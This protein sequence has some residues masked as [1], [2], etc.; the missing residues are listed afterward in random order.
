M[1]R[2]SHIKAVVIMAML[3][4]SVAATFSQSPAI[5]GLALTNGVLSV[6]FTGGELQTSPTVS[7]LW[8]GTGNTSG[9]YSESVVGGTNKFYRVRGQS[10]V[11]ISNVSLTN[12]TVQYNALAVG[13][14]VYVDRTNITFTGVASLGGS[15]YIQTANDDKAASTNPFLT[16]DVSTNVVI[17][18]AHDDMITPKPSWLSAFSDTGENLVGSNPATYSLYAAEFAAG[19][20]TLGGNEG[21][22]AS[23][24]YSV[25]ITPAPTAPPG[26]ATNPNPTNSATS[27][28]VNAVLS[29]TPGSKAF[30]HDV[31]FGTAN[32]PPFKGNQTATTYNPG[33][34]SPFTTYYWRINEKNSKGT[35][36]GTVWSFT[37]GAAAALTISNVS[38]VNYT[39]QYDALAVGQLIYVDRTYTFTN[40]ASLG[41]S[42]Y[43]K[44]ANGDKPSTAN[45]FLTFDVSANVVVYVAHDDKMTNK[46]SWLTSFS[47]TGEN[48]GMNTAT[49]S[50]YAAEFAA[51]TVTLG[52]NE[53][54]VS[55][56][57]YS[58]V[59]TPA[60]TGPPGTASNPNPTNSATSVSVNA[61]LSWTPGSKAFSHDVYFGTA[62]PPA[63]QG[64]QTG[65]TYNPGALSASTTYYWRINEKNSVG[66]TTGTVWSFTTGTSP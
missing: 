48:I 30:S 43:I 4:G 65:P 44:T 46:P 11:T 5:T 9:Q 50:L 56:S 37:T 25:V 61:I 24:M 41:G 1:K 16:F 22:G 63:F 12:Y 51:G 2:I 40:V 14:L 6:T 23:S 53:G 8:T 57:M 59:I 35:T 60:P 52:G 7:G 45:P 66:T 62:N 20:V 27:F 17:Y 10:L 26:V 32:P 3:L 39:V 38:R 42:T 21:G 49:F 64:N 54:D 15:T 58:V 55:S 47:D 19:T 13:Q 33:V 28:S 36:T 34:L 29:W 31:Y 18:V